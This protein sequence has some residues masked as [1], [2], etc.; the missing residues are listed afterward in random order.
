MKIELDDQDDGLG[1]VHAV[2]LGLA[3]E[4]GLVFVFLL[5][6]VLVGGTS[7]NVIQWW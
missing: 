1:C 2:G 4:A 7:F 5:G 3:I 6:I